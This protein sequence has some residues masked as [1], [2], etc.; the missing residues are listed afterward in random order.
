VTFAIRKATEADAAAIIALLEGIASERIHTSINKPWSAD[1]QR[2]YIG[3]LSVREAIHVAETEREGI[4]GYQT[5]DLLAPTIDCL[6]LGGVKPS[7]S[8]DG[9]S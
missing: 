5:L 7:P 3:S 1:R 4:I 6:H 8:G 2:H 9:F